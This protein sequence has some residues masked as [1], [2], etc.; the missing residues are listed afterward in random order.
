M[1]FILIIKLKAIW[2]FRN[3]TRAINP[4]TMVSLNLGMV[5]CTIDTFICLR[6]NMQV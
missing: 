4:N 5:Y 1:E 6:V 3:I 2:F